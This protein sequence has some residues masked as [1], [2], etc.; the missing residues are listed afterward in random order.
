M[1][2][3][4]FWFF[5][6]FGSTFYNPSCDICFRV[7]GSNYVEVVK[8]HMPQVEPGQPFL[9]TRVLEYISIS[10]LF[11]RR[12]RNIFL[13]KQSSRIFKTKFTRR[14]R[15]LMWRCGVVAIRRQ[16]IACLLAMHSMYESLA[17][18]E[19]LYPIAATEEATKHLTLVL[20]TSRSWRIRCIKGC[21]CSKI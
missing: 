19:K 17:T 18:Q 4:H 2:Y 13:S 6:F 3:G 16:Q 7:L 9:R 15:K 5:W 1:S 21:P 14:S 11:V 12:R 10:T 20:E 8:C